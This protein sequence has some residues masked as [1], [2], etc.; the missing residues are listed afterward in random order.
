MKQQFCSQKIMRFKNKDT[1][2]VKQNWLE[3]RSE[4]F[5]VFDLSQPKWNLIFVDTFT[6]IEH[7]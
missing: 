1:V 5:N 2:F 3:I 7:Q 4:A 6:K